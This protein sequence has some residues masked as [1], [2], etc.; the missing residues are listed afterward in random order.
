MRTSC[1]TWSVRRSLAGLA[2]A[3]AALSLAQHSRRKTC[4]WPRW[5]DNQT[6]TWRAKFGPSPV[7]LLE[8][9]AQLNRHKRIQP[10]IHQTRAAIWRAVRASSRNTAITRERHIIVHQLFPFI[11]ERDFQSLAKFPDALCRK[12]ASAMAAAGAG[13][14]VGIDIKIR[15]R[16]RQCA[17]WSRHRW[18]RCAPGSHA[19]R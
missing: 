17:G 19:G 10:R 2:G 14:Q 18:R 15:M 1:R 12:G 16:R 13:N 5:L 9:I 6:S 3:V 4:R 11:R 8:L 7:L